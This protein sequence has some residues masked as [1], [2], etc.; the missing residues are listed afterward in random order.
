VQNQ[1]T[2][3]NFIFSN[4]VFGCQWYCELRKVGWLSACEGAIVYGL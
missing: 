2:V 3:A 1:I 4:F